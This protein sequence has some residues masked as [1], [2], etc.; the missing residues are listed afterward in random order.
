MSVLSWCLKRCEHWMVERV[1]KVFILFLVFSFSLLLTSL[2]YIRSNGGCACCYWRLIYRVQYVFSGT[3]VSRGAGI[4]KLATGTLP[5]NYIP[6][7]L[8]HVQPTAHYKWM[9]WDHQPCFRLS[10]SGKDKSFQHICG[11]SLWRSFNT[12]TLFVFSAAINSYQSTGLFWK[13]GWN[14][15]WKIHF[16][17]Y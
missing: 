13:I 1:I 11:S 5:G 17:F 4:D 7:L 9:I 12:L 2:Q 16:C 15:S 3:N 6:V 14:I 8:Y 10:A